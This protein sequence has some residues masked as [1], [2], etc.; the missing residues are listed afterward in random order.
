MDTTFS[1]TQI[2]ALKKEIRGIG[3]MSEIEEAC[4]RKRIAKRTTVFTALNA[5]RYN[6]SNPIHRLIIIEAIEIV[7]NHGGDIPEVEIQAE[8]A[9]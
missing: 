8:L 6:D 1:S 5:E 3:L 9:A 7:K 4:E 2:S